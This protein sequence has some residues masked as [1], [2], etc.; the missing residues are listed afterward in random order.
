MSNSTAAATPEP[1]RDADPRL[2]RFLAAWRA[3]R[4]GA[5]MPRR[6]AFDPMT[7]PDLLPWIWLCAYDPAADDFVYR[8]AGEEVNAAW[9]RSLRGAALRDL[10]GPED[11]PTVRRRW[12]EILEGPNL[13]YGLTRE[14]LS[15][16][17]TQSAERLLAPL[18]DDAG[19]PAYILGVSLYRV[20]ASDPGRPPLTAEDYVRL[21]VAAL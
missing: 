15:A 4:A 1:L 19:L 18:A 3:A 21:P 2:L 13:H 11:H 8:L 14:R 9:G 20:A 5:P 10:L 16:L 17:E 6:R 7:A 12:A